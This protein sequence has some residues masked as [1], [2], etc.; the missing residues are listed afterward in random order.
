MTAPDLPLTAEDVAEIAQ[1]LA[2]S[3]YDALDV[4]TRRF[5]LRLAAADAGEAAGQTA[6]T[7]EWQWA[8]QVDAS[9]VGAAADAPLDPDAIPAPLPGTFYHA[10]Q[11]GAP[12][13]VAAG[14]AVEAET[15][16]GIIET[17]KLMNPVHAGRAGTIEAVL[18]PDG[19]LV[20]KGTAL[21]RLN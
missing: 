4:S 18:V 12:S 1:I 13:F 20:A 5:R 6:F 9:A 14:D 11:P 16:V 8:G 10:P 2:Q 17:M 21:F 3:G 15:V 19:T 7:Q